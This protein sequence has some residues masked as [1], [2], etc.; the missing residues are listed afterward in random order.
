MGDS[1]CDE[2]ADIYSY[3]IVLHEICSGGR[4]FLFLLHHPCQ[5]IVAA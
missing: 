5:P 1:P 3:G 2:S 4:A